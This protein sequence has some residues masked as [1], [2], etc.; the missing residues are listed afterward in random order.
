MLRERLKGAIEAIRDGQRFKLGDLLITKDKNTVLVTGWTESLHLNVLT[1]SIAKEEL[2]HIKQDFQK[3]VSSSDDWKEFVTDKTI[4]YNLDYD[5]FG[6]GGPGICKEV[7]GKIE[8]MV[9]LTP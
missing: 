7:N 6:K 2:A 9:E 1:K 4:Q 3:L 5:E 8:W